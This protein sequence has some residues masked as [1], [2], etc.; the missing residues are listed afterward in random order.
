MGETPEYKKNYEQFEVAVCVVA[1]RE[2]LCG[3][4]L[5]GG[6]V[7]GSDFFSRKQL[8]GR[9]LPGGGTVRMGVISRGNCLGGINLSSKVHLYAFKMFSHVKIK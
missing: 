5:S 6:E 9:E 1:T 3:G 7:S 2:E 4:E 8:F